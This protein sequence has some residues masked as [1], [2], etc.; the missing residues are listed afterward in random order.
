MTDL[1][2][3]AMP[4]SRQHVE[5]RR[6]S[7]R[8]EPLGIRIAIIAIA[9]GFLALFII[10]PLVTVFIQAFSKGATAYFGALSDPDAISAIRLTL[11]IAAISVAVNLVFGVIAAWAI[12]KFEF[13]GKT[14]LITLIDLPFFRF[15]CRLRSRFCAPFRR[16]G[17]LRLLAHGE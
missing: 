11:L 17:H 3:T 5:E 1:A 6:A 7:V 12:T 2:S 9:I 15:A 8:T 4:T 13:P 16:A 10:L 14:F